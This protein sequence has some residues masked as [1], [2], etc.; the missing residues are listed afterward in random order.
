MA[1][2]IGEK[3]PDFRLKGVDGKEYS[4]ADFADKKAVAVIFSCNHCP[5]VQAW[6]Q[7]LIDIQA[8]YGNRG[9]QLLLICSNDAVAY[10]EDS[11][12]KM[13]ERAQRLG[14]NM[15]YLHDPTQETARAYGAEKTP[16]IF[17]L[18]SEGVV[19]YHGAPDDNYED[20]AAVK[21]HYLRDALDAVL[22]GKEP[23]TATTPPVG[24]TIK[25]K[26]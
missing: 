5:Y 7:R 2:S 3:A 6:E 25:W 21:Q 10:P 24:C 17:L 26:R 15:P 22:E 8:D 9:A 23:T 18:D 13:A 16:E 19:R 20:A 1:L 12:D 4:L 14:Y 11:F